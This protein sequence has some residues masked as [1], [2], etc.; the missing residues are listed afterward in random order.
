MDV[1]QTDTVDP[2]YREA[3]RR[4]SISNRGFEKQRLGSWSDVV[5]LFAN[6]LLI[7]P[8]A[9]RRFPKRHMP[10]LTAIFNAL[11][12]RRSTF[13]ALMRFFKSDNQFQSNGSLRQ[14]RTALLV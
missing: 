12:G 6:G 13:Y 5:R 10:W 8:L 7:P 1:R 2:L 3:H 11:Q 4:L 9:E 14:G